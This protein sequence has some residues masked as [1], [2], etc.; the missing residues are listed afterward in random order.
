MRLCMGLICDDFVEKKKNYLMKNARRKPRLFLSTVRLKRRF[1][2]KIKVYAI[3]YG[4]GFRIKTNII[5]NN[6]LQTSPYLKAFLF[7][8]LYTEGLIITG[9]CGF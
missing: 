1:V 9:K 2:Q 6:I 3:M 8:V 7:L 5:L 4:C